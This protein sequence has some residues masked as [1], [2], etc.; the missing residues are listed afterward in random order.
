MS[1]E[2]EKIAELLKTIRDA[3]ALKVGARL[4]PRS[5]GTPPPNRSVNADK[6]ALRRKRYSAT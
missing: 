1:E 5:L 6:R 2:D 3:R 4:V